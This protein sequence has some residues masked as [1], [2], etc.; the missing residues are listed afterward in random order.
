MLIRLLF[1]RYLL[2][3][4]FI[5]QGYFF[6]K[7]LAFDKIEGSGSERWE[8]LIGKRLELSFTVNSLLNK[9]V[10]LPLAELNFCRIKLQRDSEE[11]TRSFDKSIIYLAILQKID[12]WD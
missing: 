9:I 2:L 10:N 12:L 8:Y 4:G 7:M 6:D 11:Q 1:E 3:R 5:G